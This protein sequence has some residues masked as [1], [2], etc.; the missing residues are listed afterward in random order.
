MYCFCT[1]AYGEEY[2][3]L[4]K[5]LA[6]DVK[7]YCYQVPFIVFT[8]KKDYFTDISQVKVFDYRPHFSN[9][10]YDKILAVRKCLTIYDS[11]IY[12]DADSRIY[13]EVNTEKK[14]PQGIAALTCYSLTEHFKGLITKRMRKFSTAHDEISSMSHFNPIKYLRIMR[15]KNY[16]YKS[17][18]KLNSRW[19]RVQSLANKL[20]LN[21]ENVKFIHE[22]M[23]AVTK[24]KGREKEF[25]KQYDR[26]AAYLQLYGFLDS[27][28]T[29]IGLAAEKAGLNISWHGE[30]FFDDFPYFKDRILKSNQ[31]KGQKVDEKEIDLL[32]E[33]N[34]VC[35]G[36]YK[37]SD[38]IKKRIQKIYLH[39][40]LLIKTLRNIKFYYF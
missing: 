39:A 28:G 11:A 9:C 5:R 10:V 25:F 29:A 14:L 12:I 16:H 1:I 17:L 37:L 4:A 19:N 24:Q 38:N 20:K 15:R 36:R 31:R 26:I 23:F 30:G 2:V 22:I 7:R 21:L 32:L 6:K 3:I 40:K 13:K 27:E 35:I 8:D 33:R 34:S 18:S